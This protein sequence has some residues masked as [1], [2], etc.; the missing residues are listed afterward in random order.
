M[1]NGEK[2]RLIIQEASSYEGKEGRRDP[3]TS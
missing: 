1:K 3:L 2:W